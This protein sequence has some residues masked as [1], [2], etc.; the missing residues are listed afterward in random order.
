[1]K[2]KKETWHIG[3]VPCPESLLFLC[4][5]KYISLSMCNAGVAQTTQS[6]KPDDC[7]V[8]FG[9]ARI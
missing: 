4:N 3:T 7:S 2:L 6:F 5:R 9:T 8:I 1:M